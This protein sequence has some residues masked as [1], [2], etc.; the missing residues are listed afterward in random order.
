MNNEEFLFSQKYRPKTVS[1]CILP[2]RLKDLFQSYVNDRQ[3]PNLLLYSGS[4][5]GKTTTARAICEEIGLDYLIIN[6]SDENGVDTVRNK[7]TNYASSMS[8]KG[9]KK[10]IIIDEMEYMSLNAQAILRH[11]TEEFSHN[12]TFIFTCNY[13][14]KIIEPL[15]SRCAVID[16]SLKA[17]EKPEMAAL[18]FDRV[19]HILKIESIE[20]DAKVIVEIIK[21]YFPDY[22][23]VLNEL[24]RYSKFG[25]IDTGI[26]SDLTDESVKELIKHIASKDFT[27]MRKWVG[28]HGL[29]ASNIYRQIY[30]QLSATME[31]DSVPAA[32]M[33]LGDYMYKSAFCS[34]QE[35]NLAACCTELMVECSFLDK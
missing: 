35:I 6:G 12:C 28:I 8:L 10:V 4:G 19:K 18:F 30:D 32:V 17:N 7:I 11:A 23:R 33:I 29:D 9:G 13:P 27:A 31:A 2:K 21:K 3:V 20:Y 26:L 24:Q 34:D 16:F 22:R 1:E 14:S 15:H 25:K 5:M